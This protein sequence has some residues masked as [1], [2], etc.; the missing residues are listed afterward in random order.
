MTPPCAPLPFPEGIS[1]LCIGS[2]G[3]CAPLPPP[4]PAS[5]PPP[6]APLPAAWHQLGQSR[7]GQQPH[8]RGQG[9]PSTGV[10][11]PMPAPGKPGS[12]LLPIL[13]ER[14][15][16]L[17]PAFIPRPFPCGHRSPLFPRDR[18][19]LGM[20]T[21]LG[22]GPP[23]DSP[24]CHIPMGHSNTPN[25]N[26]PWRL[27][28]THSAGAGH[29]GFRGVPGKGD[30]WAMGGTAGA[31]PT[32]CQLFSTAGERGAWPFLGAALPLAPSLAPPGCREVPALLPRGRSRLLH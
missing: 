6:G 4:P 27:I 22:W 8:E 25:A 19:N 21:P 11:P 3:P 5:C 14:F 29:P 15:W 10:R 2:G 7:G 31:R 17:F 18:D 28:G 9:V 16:M 1:A 26:I 12:F 32:A 23:G 30:P 20:G 24:R 13:P